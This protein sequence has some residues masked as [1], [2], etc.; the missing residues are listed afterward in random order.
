MTACWPPRPKPD[1]Q[2]TAPNEAE[3]DFH[4]DRAGIILTSMRRFPARP[5]LGAKIEKAVIEVPQH[6]DCNA[7][8][9]TMVQIFLATGL[10]RRRP[11][12]TQVARP[13]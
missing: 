11:P 10:S 6:L 3:I 1:S 5:L 9:W 8:Q 2:Q 12:T 4:F 13:C 7:P